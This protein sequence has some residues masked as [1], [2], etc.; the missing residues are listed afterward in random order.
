MESGRR[1]TSGK[2]IWPVDIR[3]TAEEDDATVGEENWGCDKWMEK[4]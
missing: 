4:K 2:Y 3:K 1:K